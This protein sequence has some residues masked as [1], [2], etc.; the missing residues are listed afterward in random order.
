M[1]LNAW[2]K[3]QKTILLFQC[4]LKKKTIM[5]KKSHINQSL[6]IATDLS[7]LHYQIWLIT[8]LAF[9]IKNVRDA[10]KEKN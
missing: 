8:Y 3:I 9:M 5:V 1:N 4:R 6:L 7:Q 2:E 10:W